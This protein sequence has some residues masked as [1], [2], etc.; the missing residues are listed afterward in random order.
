MLFFLAGLTTRRETVERIFSCARRSST[1]I[2]NELTLF[3][4]PARM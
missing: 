1:T 3:T 4:N 2:I